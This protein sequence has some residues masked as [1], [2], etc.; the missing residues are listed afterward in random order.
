[1]AILAASALWHLPGEARRLRSDIEAGRRGAVY[2]ELQPVR[3]VGLDDRLFRAAPRLIPSGARFYVLTGPE[4]TI[5][6]PLVLRWAPRFARYQLL[7]RRLTSTVTTAD[8][9]LSY[10]GRVPAREV[11][12]VYTVGPGLTV[13]RRA[14]R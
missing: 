11:D 8:W 6:D 5:E 9:I 2:R 13:A 12:R 1:V 10:G 14:T 7:P 3:T 4:A